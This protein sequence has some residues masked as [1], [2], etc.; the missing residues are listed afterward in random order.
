MQGTQSQDR[1][2]GALAYI[3]FLIP[4]L[5]E[6]KTEYV[7]FHMKQSFFFFVIVVIA[8]FIPFFGH[9][10]SVLIFFHVVFLMWKAYNGEKFVVPYIA[11]YPEKLIQ[12]LGIGS[13]FIPKK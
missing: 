7:C 9:M 11:G 1:I 2:A 8:G 10:I 5:M 6:Q 3:F 12:L 13:L 4:V